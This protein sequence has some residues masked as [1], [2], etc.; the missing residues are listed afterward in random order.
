MGRQRVT[1]LTYLPI[2]N[3][4]CPDS[5]FMVIKLI[6]ESFR[7][8][9][10]A[11]KM[12]VLR[13]VLS[14]LGV[15]IG[16]TTIIGVFTGV[17]SLE[18]NLK[19]S[20]EFLGAKVM[21]I[22]KWPWSFEGN[23]PWWEYINRPQTTY[24][25][26]EFLE[27][28][29]VNRTGISIFADKGNLTLKRNSNSI[30]GIHLSGIS[31]G[32]SE[33]YDMPISEGRY[34]TR[35]EI[36]SGRNVVLIGS[37][38]HEALFPQGGALGEDVKIRGLR[39]TVI[40]VLKTQGENLIGAPS[41]DD[42]CFIPYKSFRKMYATGSRFGVE[43]VVAV[44]GLEE[45]ENLRELEGELEGLMRRKRGLKPKDD[46]NFALNRSE[47]VADQLGLLFDQ[48][49]FIGGVIGMF[50]LLVGGFGIANIMFVS[51]KER[52]SIIGIQKSLGAKNYFILFQFLFEAIFL[53]VIGGVAGLLV[54]YLLS[55]TLNTGSLE[56]ALTFKNIL[57]G[58]MVA[59]TV[60]TIS[61]IIPAVMASRMDPVQAIRTQ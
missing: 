56:L 21:Y 6:L 26:Y 41:N 36:R 1:L 58:L 18:Q 40:G 22:Q 52:T 47:M 15:M 25:E 3:W 11:L 59:V 61:G 55:I 24:E 17:D 4:N 31:Y 50:A 51:V 48:V 13:T 35:T 14:L 60:G 34:F 10:S 53:S 9:W 39:F 49:S 8:A 16:I 28:T 45:D 19:D 12:N 57:L 23:Y 5:Q 27:S 43:S 44:K 20:F 46:S 42:K 7:F 2:G 54:V 37:E 38:V 33:V 29:V 32:H 30:S